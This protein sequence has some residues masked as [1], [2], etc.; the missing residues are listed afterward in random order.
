MGRLRS[1][2]VFSDLTGGI[3]NVDTKETINAS[4][5]HTETPDMLNVEYFGLGGIKSMEGNTQIG[6]TQSSAVVG[7]YEY[8]KGNKRYMMIATQDG[9]V[10]EY[11]PVTN[12]YDS[13]Y[14]FNSNSD[15]VSFCNMNNG[16][17][18]SNGKDDLLFYEKGRN[19]QLT[20]VIN[21]N[22]DY[23]NKLYGKDTI[24][25]T[26]LNIGDY[27]KIENC[28]GYYKII[29]I[30]SNTIAT[31][32]KDIV[33]E[34]GRKY[35]G[36]NGYKYTE[37]LTSSDNIY[38]LKS[39]TL[40]PKMDNDVD[41]N[42]INIYTRIG[43]GYS[44][45]DNDTLLI[46]N[47]TLQIEYGSIFYKYKNLFQ[48]N[49]NIFGF[50]DGITNGNTKSFFYREHK[51]YIKDF[52]VY[53]D[54]VNIVK[55]EL[56][57][58]I[59]DIIWGL[60]NH[61]WIAFN[62]YIYRV[63]NNGNTTTLTT[64]TEKDVYKFCYHPSHQ[65]RLSSTFNSIEDCYQTFK[66]DT[67]I[68]AIDSNGNLKIIQSSLGKVAG[69]MG[70]FN[71]VLAKEPVYTCCYS[72]E[73][74][75][76]KQTKI[77]NS[78]QKSTYILSSSIAV[79]VSGFQCPKV[80][81]VTGV[82][83]QY[84]SEYYAMAILQKDNKNS[85]Y[86]LDGTTSP[87]KTK[88]LDWNNEEYEPISLHN[89]F[90]VGRKSDGTIG[91][92]YHIP[93]S[94]NKPLLVKLYN[95]N[96][97]E[98]DITNIISSGDKLYFDDESDFIPDYDFLIITDKYTYKDIAVSDI[99]PL[100]IPITGLWKWNKYHTP[101]YD[102]PDL[103]H[104]N[105]SY[106]KQYIADGETITYSFNPI[107]LTS[108]TQ[109]D[110]LSNNIDIYSQAD[111]TTKISNVQK[112][113]I[114]YNNNLQLHY[115]TDNYFYYGN[116]DITLDEINYNEKPPTKNLSV[117]LSEISECN[118]YLVNTDPDLASGEN[119]HT[120]IRGT[121]IQYYNGRLWVGTDNG[122]FYS[123]V[124][125]PNNWDIYSDAGVLYSIY[126]DSSKIG[127][128]GLFSEYLMV[129][130]EFSTYILT[131]S[132]ESSTIE[133]KPFSN[134]TCESQQGWIVSNTKY[135]VFSKDFLDIYPLIQHTVFNDKFLGEPV[136]QKVR[137][138]FKYIRLEDTDKI[139]C[140][141]RPRERQMVFY[142][143]MSYVNGSAIALIFDFQTK[144]WLLRQ[145]PQ[146]VTTAFQYNNKIY[147]GTKDGKALEEFKG[148]TFDGKAIN[149][150]YKS[151]WFDWA[152]DYTQ[153]FSEFI[154]E[155]DNSVNNTFK[156]NTYKD[157]EDRTETRIINTD[158]L[159]KKSLVWGN[160]D[161]TIDFDEENWN[162]N[163]W[164]GG[165]FESIRMVLPNNVFDNFQLEFSTD[166]DNPSFR[167]YKYGF[168]RIETEEVPW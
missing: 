141:G 34:N 111:T 38:R 107:G 155:V 113:E 92:F 98:G 86:Y 7:G 63:T 69:V 84:S 129:H 149:A 104:C 76:L 160:S 97:I 122:L 163:N 23:K 165:T 55:N 142:L 162:D 60:D 91:I 58:G 110:N 27:I 106:G 62:E 41:I 156:I 125:L 94:L 77:I 22:K 49:K 148:D 59:N 10:K 114:S 46:E 74:G 14:K 153:S 164:A 4:P 105:L 120:P 57:Y 70:K 71:P 145:V 47:G 13:V 48:S 134:I 53:D 9:N 26:E 19:T 1:Q 12:K 36:W 82:S 167:I 18:V 73:N 116:R 2:L 118:A 121:A 42:S 115:I 11:N 8:T 30:E 127:A 39:I 37:N 161:D 89:E 158:R 130:K 124:G 159:L 40:E 95:K 15:K 31:L 51:D 35:Y 102:Y 16:V 140:V 28:S 20:G 52:I 146:D 87:V 65:I 143:P 72:I 67:A 166:K 168:R 112:S 138:L 135:F 154:I 88:L 117:N 90:I 157:G 50:T 21:Y 151:P 136:T 3:N 43:N 68:F 79:D 147:I 45:I 66:N 96:I 100:H 99:I 54:G 56:A 101:F 126:N 109:N 25:K 152:G 80:E 32:D 150:Y 131:C 81:Y 133:V 128:L 5:R 93:T 61:F 75:K 78:S 83:P 33:I 137:N 64:G 132:G 144:S 44:S 108:Y 85:L 119:I 29:N 17:V 123:A 139:F 103:E 24:F 6:D